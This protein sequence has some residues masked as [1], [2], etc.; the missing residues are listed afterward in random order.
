MFDYNLALFDITTQLEL[1]GVKITNTEILEK[2]SLHIVLQQKYQNHYFKTYSKLI[3]VLMSTTRT[4]ELL[5]KNN[6]LCPISISVIPE[7]HADSN[8]SSDHF[9]GCGQRQSHSF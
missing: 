3:S 2:N 4:N 8:K 1:C 6:N 5:L 9:R 7:A